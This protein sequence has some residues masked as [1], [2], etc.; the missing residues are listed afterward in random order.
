M[1]L[2]A[3]EGQAVAACAS[4]LGSVG[5]TT[6][7]RFHPH[8]ETACEKTKFTRGLISAESVC[9]VTAERLPTGQTM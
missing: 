4:G 7:I 8:M 2:G 6:A 1:E 9:L 5:D 3:R